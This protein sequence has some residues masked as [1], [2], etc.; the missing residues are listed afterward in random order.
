[1][2]LLERTDTATFVF[3]LLLSR[4]LFVHLRSLLGRI[5]LG[6][7]LR[8]TS[9]RF[10]HRGGA[11]RAIRTSRGSGFATSDTFLFLRDLVKNSRNGPGGD[12]D[13]PQRYLS[14]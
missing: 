1:M 8:S 14:I 13:Q 11:H 2:Q 3:F 12:H 6:P 4:T 9:S 5:L 10:F 7:L